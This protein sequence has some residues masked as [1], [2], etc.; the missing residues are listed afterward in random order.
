[1][2]RLQKMNKQCG[3]GQFSV[4]S[5][6]TGRQKRILLLSPAVPA[7]TL[8]AIDGPAHQGRLPTTRNPS[9]QEEHVR[10]KSLPILGTCKSLHTAAFPATDRRPDRLPCAR[11]CACRAEGAVFLVRKSKISTVPLKSLGRLLTQAACAAQTQTVVMV[12]RR[13]TRWTTAAVVIVPVFLLTVIV[14][15]FAYQMLVFRSVMKE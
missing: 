1:M 14:C 5:N 3:S 8:L 13:A 7:A 2:Q 4:T 11:T 10:C 15:V 12:A 9:C 6:K